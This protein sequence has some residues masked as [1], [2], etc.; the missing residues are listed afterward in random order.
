MEEGF[1][2]EGGR[3][4]DR[5]R[6]ICSELLYEE[7]RPLK[8]RCHTIKAALI[9]QMLFPRPLWLLLGFLP[10]SHV[11]G[12]RVEGRKKERETSPTNYQFCGFESLITRQRN[13]KY[14]KPKCSGRWTVPRLAGRRACGKVTWPTLPPPHHHPGSPRARG[15]RTI[16][17]SSELTLELAVLS[18]ARGMWPQPRCSTANQQEP[19]ACL[20][21]PHSYLPWTCLTCLWQK[22]CKR[23]SSQPTLQVSGIQGEGE[24]KIN[25]KKAVT[26]QEFCEV[27]VTLIKVPAVP[28]HEKCM[29]LHGSVTVLPLGYRALTTYF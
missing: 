28:Q 17:S 7:F 8:A 23:N 10:S 2:K 25:R 11:Q 27:L 1:W 26:K 29:V 3:A 9:W 12:K 13:Q 20:A 18:I 6:D 19:Q 5:Q 15:P 14:W 16:Y 24:L 22:R 21:L 4:W